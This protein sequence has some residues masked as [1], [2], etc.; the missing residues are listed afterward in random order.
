MAQLQ[1]SEDEWLHIAKQIEDDYRFADADHQERM[2]KNEEYMA[3]WHNLPDDKGKEAK[4]KAKS[5]F[6]IPLL[7]WHSMGRNSQVMQRIFGEDA[8]IVASPVGSS[9]AA[10]AAK[11]S[12]FLN[13]RWF[14]SMK[15]IPQ[16]MSFLFYVILFGRA[17]AYRPWDTESYEISSKDGKRRW[18]KFY[19]G[20]KF[21]TIHP[22]DLIVPAEEVCSIQDFSYVIRRFW[23]SPQKLLEGEAKGQYFGIAAN[24]EEVVLAAAKRTGRD[25][26]N[27]QDEDG[28]RRPDDVSEGVDY[29][30]D[31]S[32]NMLC[33]YEW[34]SGWRLPRDPM[35]DPPPELNDVK[36]RDLIE[37]QLVIWY[38]PDMKLVIGGER[39]VDL[40]PKM[41]NKR[42]F[43]EASLIKNGQYWAPGFG[44]LLS[45][46]EDET[47]KNHQLFADAGKLSVWPI[48]FYDPNSGYDPEGQPM[49]PGMA[50]PTRNASGVKVVHVQPDLQFTQQENQQLR[51]IAEL[52]SGVSDSQLGKVAEQPNAPRTARGQIALLAKGDIRAELDVMALREDLN[53][54]ANDM[55]DM[56]VNFG[57]GVVFF[58]VTESSGKSVISSGAA[59]DKMTAKE[60]GGKY[61]ISIKFATAAWNR[62][63]MRQN[64]LNAYQVLVQSNP[65]LAQDPRFM[66]TAAKM[67]LEAME[68]PA[69]AD[70][71]E[72]PPEPQK[73]RDPEK[74]WTLILQGDGDKVTVAPTDDDALHLKEHTAQL[75]EQRTQPLDDQDTDAIAELRLHM[76]EHTQAMRM[77]QLQNALVN[78]VVSRI[79]AGAHN[80]MGLQMPQQ[81]PMQN[82]AA[83]VT[84]MAGGQPPTAEGPTQ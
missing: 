1:L 79:S 21:Y 17:H 75:T 6:R 27:K 80:G 2:R 20:P 70:L 63:A 18:K 42:P 83:L 62:D 67:I 19:E 31:S 61:D 76:Q 49:E 68:L 54:I 47:S 38:V 26:P 59:F 33:V 35:A 45:S 4:A 66:M 69:L 64:T 53:V 60:R 55:W 23:L 12:K 65:W 32:R 7:Q 57:D 10:A 28:S 30:G 56:E 50:Y 51:G 78:N 41:K 3:R 39:L 74:E 44:Q 5:M 15:I 8:E 73:S 72:I 24:F 29:Y 25:D 58:R 11:V 37:T 71:I 34:Y 14:T 77:K 36:A 9:D 84:G 40:Y 13:W 48:V 46:I 22:D 81:M 16:M 82:L 43:A 52:V